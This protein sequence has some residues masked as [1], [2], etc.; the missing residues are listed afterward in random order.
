LAILSSESVTKNRALFLEA[1]RWYKDDISRIKPWAQKYLT[2][3][4]FSLFLNL[5]KQVES[6]GMVKDAWFKLLTI[7]LRRYRDF[8]HE[9]LQTENWIDAKRVQ[10]ELEKIDALREDLMSSAATN[11]SDESAQS[12]TNK[13]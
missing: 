4:R 10:K 2:D 8:L 1:I 7:A 13:D 9:Q 5:E 6:G 11:H 3:D 12:T